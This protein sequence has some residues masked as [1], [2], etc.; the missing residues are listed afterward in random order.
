VAL[1]AAIVAVAAVVVLSGSGGTDPNVAYR[2][3]LAATLAPVLVANRVL[4]S[5]LQA[6]HRTNTTAAQNA[7][8]QAQS[9]VIAARGG[10]AVLTAPSASTQVSQQGGCPDRRGSSTAILTG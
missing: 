3:K 8:T 7:G 2:Q 10:V 5:S 4:S 6:L 1:L 9:A